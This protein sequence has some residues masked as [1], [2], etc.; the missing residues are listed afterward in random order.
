MASTSVRALDK[1][2]LDHT[3]PIGRG[4]IAFLSAMTEDRR[5]RII[6]RANDGRR[7]AKARG[8]KFGREPKLNEHRCKQAVKR[9]RRGESA[10]VARTFNLHHAM[11]S[12]LRDSA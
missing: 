11:V 2:Y 12:R 3:T 5:R 1:R 4:F 10:A 6:K 8:A 7:A 9:F